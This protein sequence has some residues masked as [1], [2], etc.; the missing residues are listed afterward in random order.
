MRNHQSHIMPSINRRNIP[1]EG[2]D[3]YPTPPW[4]TK[5][6]IKYETF[7][8]TILEPCCGDGAMAEILKDTGCNI[9]ASDLHDRGYGTQAD[10]LSLTGPYTN[11]V[12]NPPFNIAED[13]LDHALKIATNKVCLLVRAPFLES[14]SRYHR[15]YKSQPPSRVYMFTERL[16]IYPAGQS[17][18]GGGTIAYCWM[19][20]DK[21]SIDN[22][23]E[24]RWIEP[25]LKKIG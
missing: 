1:L 20:W 18:K 3:F 25:G 16:S 11:I 2:A 14:V 4:G 12:T 10:F 23:T 19:V 13:I 7:T 9:I 6:L 8:G 17:A 22:I 15:F 21:A 5:A 24:L